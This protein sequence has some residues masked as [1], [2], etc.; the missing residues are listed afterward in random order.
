MDHV[1]DGSRR[2]GLDLY[3]H[4]LTVPQTQLLG[5]QV[6][7]LLGVDRYSSSWR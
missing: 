2:P 5:L 4:D 6:T 1:E 7:R 3:R